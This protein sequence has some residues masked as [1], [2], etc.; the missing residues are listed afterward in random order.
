MMIYHDSDMISPSAF[1]CT[2]GKRGYS[3][4]IQWQGSSDDNDGNDVDDEDLDLS[5]LDLNTGHP[6]GCT[7]FVFK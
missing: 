2:D 7:V 4:R 6:I 5:E 3:D 1:F